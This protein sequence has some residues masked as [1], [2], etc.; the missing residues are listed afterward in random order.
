[1]AHAAAG[2]TYDEVVA[3]ALKKLRF[4]QPQ[5]DSPGAKAARAPVLV[6]FPHPAGPSADGRAALDERLSH[7]EQA[8][9]NRKRVTMAYVT[10]SSGEK[11]VRDVD[12]YGLVYRQGAWL[13]V[14]YCHL[15]RGVR[16]FRVDR[17]EDVRVAP[18][19]RTPDFE[20]PGDFDV[21]R[22]AARSP[23]TF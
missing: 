7:L 3:L 10:A 21:R 12:P 20:R 2:T 22:Y 11:A 16:S 4:D 6:H 15:R 14:G 5:P 18:K 19:P 13:L 1:V 9:A 8:T 17:M 23:W